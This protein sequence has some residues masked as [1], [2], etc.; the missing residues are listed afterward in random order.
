M[1]QVKEHRYKGTTFGIIRPRKEVG[2]ETIR[3]RGPVVWNKQSW[4]IRDRNS[5]VETF[6]KHLKKEKVFKDINF[7]KETFLNTNFDSDYIYF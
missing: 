3:Y 5:S 7:K 1:F 4:N 2:R 6:K